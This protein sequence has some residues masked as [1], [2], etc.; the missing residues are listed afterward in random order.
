MGL[1][2]TAYSEVVYTGENDEEKFS[3]NYKTVYC[4]GLDSFPVHFDQTKTGVYFYKKQY[5]FYHSGY[6]T[7]NGWR[8]RLS[9]L[10]NNMSDREIWDSKDNKLPFYYLINFSDCEG[11]IGTDICKKLYEDFKNNANKI[12]KQLNLSDHYD[13]FFWDRYK[14]FRKAFCLASKNG[15]IRYH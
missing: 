11:T 3:E 15:V 5:D 8:N 9:M 2:I 1:D 6:G 4:Y 12:K 14:E 13:E 10:T 7:Y